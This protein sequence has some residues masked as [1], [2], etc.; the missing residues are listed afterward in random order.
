MAELVR[1][2]EAMT[3]GGQLD[4]EALKTKLRN[5]ETGDWF[6]DGFALSALATLH[7]RQNELLVA[8]RFTQAAMDKVPNETSL[9]VTDTQLMLAE[10]MN[11]LLGISANPDR[12]LETTRTARRLHAE[13]GLEYNDYEALTNFLLAFNWQ[14]DHEG[15]AAM[16]ALLEDREKP[17]GTLA[18]LFE[19]YH[20]DMLNE[21][22]QHAQ[23]LRV[24]ASTG[25][26]EDPLIR[27]RADGEAMIAH[28]GLGNRTEALQHMR[29]LGFWDK[30]GPTPKADTSEGALHA[31][32]LL[33]AASGDAA[34][35]VAL[36]NQRLDL[37]LGNL[38]RATAADTAALLSN[39]ENS[40]ERQ[41]ERE[42]R[43]KADAAASAELAAQT[44]KANRLLMALLLGLVAIFA[45]A[46]AAFRFRERNNAKLSAL[47]EQALSAEK[48]KTEFLGVVNHE[49]RTPLNGVIGISD[50]LIQHSPDE[51]TRR[52]ATA[53]LESGET[54]QNL[55]ESMID[56][57]TI[58]AG[59]FELVTERAAPGDA[60]R[61]E[62]AR[63]A[64]AAD[65]KSLAY[66]VHVAPDLDAE[67]TMD[68]ARLSQIV[69]ILLSNATRFTHQGRIHLHATAEETGD[70]ALALRLI[71]ADTGQ[72]M[73]EE[74]QDRLFQP[75]LQADATMT[76]KYGGAGLSLAIARKMAEMMGGTVSCTSTLGRGSE[77]TFT[78]ALPLAPEVAP[79]VA[80]E[81]EAEIAP[82]T[83]EAPS[84][85]PDFIDLLALA[86]ETFG[87]PVLPPAPSPARHAFDLSGTRVLVVEDLPSNQEVIRL[88]LEPEGCTCLPA[89]TGAQALSTL[90]NAPVDVILMD[91]RMPGMDGVEAT[92]RIRA[93]DGPIGKLPIIVLTADAGSKTNE[94]ALAVGADLFLTKPVM[95]RDLIGA[96]RKVMAKA[97]PEQRLSA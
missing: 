25:N 69:R 77:F 74:V 83:A 89:L 3:V 14:R 29:S 34:E 30:D 13:L 82:Q 61:E 73:S 2:F 21:M 87:V 76:R 31:R 22:G 88:M 55:I 38:R 8:A 70:G 81:P 63:W 20:A 86:P 53:I 54:L 10:Q 46:I 50:A 11:M 96:L 59:K 49:L 45:A 80:T 26:I 35:A 66:T 17:E 19:V 67:V 1:I 52:Q 48:M 68:T 79:E 6:A 75:F 18:G 85:E 40:R 32:A 97:C 15:A 56:M 41:M 95:S 91:I 9:L 60:V 24:I 16:V 65:D 7:V 62:A 23:V 42:N 27:Q 36:Q 90:A 44:A 28:A 37:M 39:L 57:S 12:M 92:R 51:K 4:R 58:E 72:G 64:K 78:A 94:L 5:F 43:L 71:V 84:A 93:L 47:R 33:A